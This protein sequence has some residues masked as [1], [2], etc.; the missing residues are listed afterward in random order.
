MSN[1][2]FLNAKDGLIVG[3]DEKN[4]FYRVDGYQHIFLIAPTGSGKGVSFVLPNLLSTTESVIVHD[5]KME[6]YAL[7][8]GWRAK[9]GQKIYMFEPLNP[10]GKTHRYNPLDFVSKNSDKMFDDI[11]KMAFILMPDHHD[12]H[13]TEERNLFIALSLYIMSSTKKTKSFGEIYRIL[14]GDVG[15]ELQSAL[16][17][18]I[19]KAGLLLISN[20]L[21][22]EDSAGAAIVSS[23]ASHLELWGNPLIDHATSKSDFNPVDFRR[24]RATLYVGLHPGDIQRLKPLMQFFYQH[25]AQSL[26]IPT[27]SKSGDT[28]GV[29]FMLDEFPTLGKMDIFTSSIPYFR[30]YKVRLLIISQDL[31]DIKSS[32]CEKGAHSLLSNSTFKVAFT[33]NNY[34]TANFISN[35]SVDGV[36]KKVMLSWQD[37]MSIGTDQQIII[38]DNQQP[39]ITKK[40]RYHEFPEFKDRIID[41]ANLKF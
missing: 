35:L 32:Y 29:L 40:L 28:H 23:L 18:K 27:D 2:D 1:K 13:H 37:A 20:F 22:N 34:D 36:T 21:S 15:K 14:M 39:M 12:Y 16:K 19:H 25:I 31:N 8:S 10:E 3:V 30:G 7:T 41:Q 33:V 26:C 17:L 6:N 9:Q 4:N 38:T 11:Q 5:I 24:E